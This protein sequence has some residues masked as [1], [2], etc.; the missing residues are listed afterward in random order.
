MYSN[1]YKQ[2][3]F[4]DFGISEF[5]NVSLGTKV[6]TTFRGTPNYCYDEMLSLMNCKETKVDLFYNDKFGLDK[7]IA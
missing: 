4:I 5:S 7:S 3:V 1:A 2:M 6:N